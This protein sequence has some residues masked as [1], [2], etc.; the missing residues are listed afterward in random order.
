MAEQQTDYDRLVVT[1]IF[2]FVAVILLANIMI[3]VAAYTFWFEKPFFHVLKAE[4]GYFETALNWELFETARYNGDKFYDTLFVRSGLEE[5][6]YEDLRNAEETDV[7]AKAIKQLKMFG[8]ILDNLFDYGLL[9]SY[10]F[11]FFS[12]VMGYM[13]ILITTVAVHG[14]IVRHRKRYG[15]GDTP[16]LL[17]LWARAMLAYSLPITFLIWTLPVA[18]HPITLAVSLTVTV[19]S[20]AAFAFSLPKI[21]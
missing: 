8:T 14:A 20:I 21:A 18:M 12:V 5:T 7:A 13:G 11:G 3:V 16:I 19:V 15:F 9:L 2:F 6:A 4:R 17:N 10:R 1:R